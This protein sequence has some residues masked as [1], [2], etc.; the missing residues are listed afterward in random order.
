MADNQIKSK[1][2]VKEHGEVFTNPREVKAMCNLVGNI[3]EVPETSVLEPACGTG[4]FLVEILERKMKTACQNMITTEE[5]RIRAV[6]AV[7]SLY[8][9]DIMEDNVKQTRDRLYGIATRF[10]MR[11]YMLRAYND[12]TLLKTLLDIDEIIS[13]NIQQGDFLKDNIEFRFWRYGVCPD[14]GI[15]LFSDK[16]TKEEMMILNNR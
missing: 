15:K 8:G 5:D 1:K 3:I 7:A 6:M 9:V 16:T 14:F 13:K 4:N 10:I 11:N 2:R 12:S